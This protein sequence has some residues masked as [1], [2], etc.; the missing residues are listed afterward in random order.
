MIIYDENAFFR[1]KKD[2]FH[3]I[4]QRSANFAGISSVTR[5]IDFI[6]D[7]KPLIFYDKNV[8][9]RTSNIYTILSLELSLQNDAVT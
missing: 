4:I 7:G 2:S 9:K 1:K 6:R 8:A 3:E 5:K